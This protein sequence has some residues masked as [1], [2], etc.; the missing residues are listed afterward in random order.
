[1]KIAIVGNGYVGTAMKQLFTDAVI[2]D[3]PLGIGSRDEVNSCDIAFVCVPTPEKESGEC[4]TS[5]VEEVIGWLETEI[6]VLRSTVPVGF[7]DS[8][9][10]RFGKNIIFQP[11]YCGETA[12]HPYA[13]LSSRSW[14]TLGGRQPYVEK[15]VNV[16]QE[17]YS[18]ELKIK[19]V[20]SKTA[21]LAKYMENSF[22]AMKVTFCNE[23]YD[24]AEK[25]GISYTELR[26]TWLMDERMGRNHTFVYPEARGFDG[27]CLPKDTSAIISQAEKLGVDMSLMHAMKQKNEKYLREN[28]SNGN[29]DK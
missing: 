27:K 25:M 19:I 10:D 21:E 18:S 7:T 2:Y 11:E 12:D 16:Y 17:V 22:L 1:M 26:E 9:I 5:I 8:M 20:D 29:S 3:E 13:N 15:V 23:F 24:L 4:D 6:I 28:S 14:I